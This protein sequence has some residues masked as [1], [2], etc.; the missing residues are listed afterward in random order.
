MAKG[1]Q[2]EDGYHW[3]LLAGLALFD[4]AIELGIPELT[5]YGFT[6]DN[7]RRPSAQT[8]A[9]RRA[10]V[11]AVELIADRDA[12][13]L[14]VGNDGS[15]TFPEELRPYRQRRVLNPSRPP[16]IRVNFLVN[17]DWAWDVGHAVTAGSTGKGRR[18]LLD[19][20]ASADVPRLDMIVRWGGRTRLSGLLPLQAVY[21]DLHTIDTLW[22]DFE[23]G[24]LLAALDWY[25]R[26]DVTLGG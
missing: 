25:Q 8:E 2:K 1:M 21:A 13:V 9:F 10:C 14:V 23:P 18:P 20:I 24:Q 16:R 22:P 17:Y 11:R 19:S 6:N 4:L 3:G 12:A 7:T 5:F 15:P 26:Q